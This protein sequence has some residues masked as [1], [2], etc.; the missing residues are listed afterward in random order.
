MNNNSTYKMPIW[1]FFG[2]GLVW[3]LLFALFQLA[4]SIVAM[5][6]PDLMDT[7]KMS[8]FMSQILQIGA[9]VFMFVLV[10]VILAWASTHAKLKYLRMY[11]FPKLQYI[12]LAVVIMLVGMLVVAMLGVVN[13]NIP[14]SGGFKDWAMGF[15]KMASDQMGVFMNDKSIGNLVLNLITVAFCAGLTEEIFFRGLLQRSFADMGV[16]K[17]VAVWSIAILFSAFHLQFMGFLPRIFLGALLGYLYAYTNNLWV[18]ILGH[19]F[20]NAFAVVA[21]YVMG[22]NPEDTP[23]AGSGDAMTWV[24]GIIALVAVIGLFVMLK[25]LADKDEPEPEFGKPVTTSNVNPGDLT[26]L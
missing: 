3:I 18:P 10:P 20:N 26:P 11:K 2:I 16:N 14:I 5:S 1:L 13:A 4:A 7:G 15:E 8:G 6:N 25:K 9:A 23:K 12:G 24:L 22:D 17:H 21:S 19:T